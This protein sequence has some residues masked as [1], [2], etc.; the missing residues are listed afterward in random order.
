MLG[1]QL[2]PA[3]V[4]GGGWLALTTGTPDM[5]AWL[6]V[7]GALRLLARGALLPMIAAPVTAQRGAW[8]RRRR[9]RPATPY[10]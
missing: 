1:I 4:G 2:A 5:F 3:V 7:A 6:L 10:T 9:A 8:A